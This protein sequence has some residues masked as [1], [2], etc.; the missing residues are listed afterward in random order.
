M[1]SFPVLVAGHSQAKC[2]GKY[3]SLTDT[4]VLSYSGFHIDQMF[5]KL[6]PTVRNYN[7][8]VLHIGANDLSRGLSVKAV[9]D[10]YQQLTSAIWDINPTADI[11]VSGLLPRASNQ[12]P[13]ALPRTDFLQDLNQR[14]HLLNNCIASLA[15]RIPLLHYVGH[16]SFVKKGT[17]QRHILSKDGLHLSFRGTSTVVKDIESAILRLH[18]TKPS[19]SIWDLPPPLQLLKR[20]NQNLL[21]QH[22]TRHHTELL[23]S[24]FQ[25][26]QQRLQ[27]L[28]TR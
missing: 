28:M 8:V 22:Q 27:Q 5:Q 6:Q 18:T 16:P 24:A 9:L 20:L 4:D 25:L 21:N 15:S 12:F 11:I 1:T 3:L 7:T 19:N 10:K 2:F 17:T 14:A 13:G 23:Y 26:H